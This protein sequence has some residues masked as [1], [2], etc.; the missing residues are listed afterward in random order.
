MD[1][2]YII[3]SDGSFMNAD[4]IYHHGILGMKWG[5]RRYQNSD[6]SLTAAGRKRYTNPDGTLNKKGQKYY[7]K[8]SERLRNEHKKLAAQKRTVEKLS[9]LDAKRKANEDLK[10][11]LNPKKEAKAETPKKKSISEMTD[12]ELNAAINRARMEDTYKQL[13]PDPVNEKSKFMKKMLNEVVVPGAINA[14]KAAMQKMIE[15]AMKDQVDPNS[16][17]ALK[18]KYDTLTI[19]KKLEKLQ[20]GEDPDAKPTSWDEKLKQQQYEANERKYAQENE[21]RTSNDATQAKKEIEQ[22]RKEATSR[23]KDSSKNT[24]N[25][26]TQARKEVEQNRK[27]AISSNK[28]SSKNASDTASAK[29]AKKA[30]EQALNNTTQKKKSNSSSSPFGDDYEKRVDKLLKEMDDKGWEMWYKE[31]GDR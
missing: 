1:S 11:Q 31:Y 15:K 25:V 21:Q 14:G 10:N 19:K 3:T 12:E 9:K 18:K 26:A 24:S 4:E 17:E 8:E 28:D 6:G 23:N 16:Y 30:T 13:R 20:K 27:E 7:A 22:N 2:N 29:Q 5:V